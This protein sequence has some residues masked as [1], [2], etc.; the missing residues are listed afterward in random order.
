MRRRYLRGHPRNPEVAMPGPE[1]LFANLLSPIVLTFALGAVAGFIRSE[2]ELHEAVL[3]LLSIYLLLSIGLTGG[4]EL[5]RVSLGD[6]SALVAAAAALTVAIPVACYPILRRFGGFDVANA[7]AVA[8]HY[9][10]V[11][12]VTFFAAIAFAR[13]M[14]NPAEGYMTAVVALMEFAV[15]I[16]LA[17]G[18]WGLRRATD[19][20]RLGGLL[21]DTL[22]GRGIL[23]LSGGM[24]IGYTA[25]DAD[26]NRI[27]PFYEQLFR[28]FLMLFLLEMGMT[29]A[30]Q[31]RAF[32]QV[33][34]FMT[35]F[36]LVAP[37]L[38][39]LTGLLA[40]WLVGLS[41][42]GAFVFA[43]IC[44]S[45]SYIDAPAACRAALPEASPGIYLTASLGITFPFNLVVNLPLLY[46]AGS[47]LYG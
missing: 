10:S 46:T 29:A 20:L 17:V 4:R 47:W 24:L 19:G 1:L 16:A 5:A 3:K 22:R 11:S 41:Q 27:A 9:G 35:G 38:L 31:I 44:A 12:S 23:L 28:G 43:A 21:V 32:A 39:G 6:I 14:G 13:A 25:S 30:R 26:W 18:R 36:A 34:R 15:V 45:A 33:G 7:A 40:G 8:A 42:G 2:L 37:V